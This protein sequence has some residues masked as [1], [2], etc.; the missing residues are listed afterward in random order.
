MAEYPNRNAIRADIARALAKLGTRHR[1]ELLELLG[2]PPDLGNVPQSFWDRVRKET[3]DELA[4]A[5][6]IAAIIAM[7]QHGMDEEAADLAGQILASERAVAAA[8]MITQ[9]SQRILRRQMTR[10]EHAASVARARAAG[11]AT[12]APAAV[13]IGA[14]V[15]EV[16]PLAAAHEAADLIFGP[17]RIVGIARN[18]S[19]IIMNEGGK[20]AIRHTGVVVTCWWR[21][22]QQA[23]PGHAGANI[24]PCEICTPWLDTEEAFWP[25]DLEPGYAHPQCDCFRSWEEIHTGRL[26]GE[27]G[28]DAGGA[29]AAA[30][31]KNSRSMIPILKGL[32]A[33][34]FKDG[35]GLS[36]SGGIVQ[37]IK[38][39]FAAC[40]TCGGKHGP[41]DPHAEPE[42]DSETKGL[43]DLAAIDDPRYGFETQ[44]LLRDRGLGDLVDRALLTTRLP[45]AYVDKDLRQAIATAAAATH[46]NPSPAQVE[47][48]N[49]P[50]GKFRVHRLE[51][52][53]E[54]PKG[55]TRSGTSAD[56][57]A[58]STVMQAHY[59]YIKRTESDAD[60][61]NIDVFI[62][63][64]PESELV[65]VVD[66]SDA[67]GRFDE[68][69]CMLG[70]HSLAEARQGYLDNYSRGWT[71]LTAITPMTLPEFH[72]WIT[73]YTG[74]P[75][76][77][78]WDESAH[79][80]VPSGSP[81]GGQFGSGAFADGQSSTAHNQHPSQH[82][83]IAEMG[84][85]SGT[86]EDP[87][88]CGKDL[89]LAVRALADGKAIQ[90]RQPRQVATLLHKMRDV[91]KECKLKGEE[92]PNF[93]LCLVSVPGTNLFC[94][95]SV[96]I[97]RAKMPQLGGKPMPNTPAMKLPINKKGEVDVSQLFIEHLQSIGIKVT[98]EMV[99]V[100]HLRASQSELVGAKVAAIMHQVE[101]GER[102]LNKGAIFATRDD[103]I[104]DGHHRWAGGIGVNLDQHGSSLEM[105][106][107][108]LDM[109]IG[110][111]IT[112]AN[113]WTRQIGIAPKE[114][115]S[116]GG[117]AMKLSDGFVR[118][119]LRKFNPD[120]A[121]DEHG[122][123]TE[124]G[125]HSALPHAD[126][127]KIAREILSQV[128]NNTFKIGPLPPT[129]RE[130]AALAFDRAKKLVK[131]AVFLPA[132]YLK[133]EQGRMAH[134]YHHL[135]EKYGKPMALA[136]IGTGLAATVGLSAM[137]VAEFVHH[138]HL[139][140]E[141]IAGGVATVLHLDE[142]VAA[143]PLVAAAEVYMRYRHG[144]DAAPHAAPPPAHKSFDDSF[145]QAEHAHIDYGH[146]QQLATEFWAHILRDA[147]D[148]AHAQPELLKSFRKFDESEARDDHGRWTSGG[149]TTTAPGD[150]KHELQVATVKPSST[151]V[152]G[153]HVNDVQVIELENGTKAIFKPESGM[154]MDVGRDGIDYGGPQREA[155]CS[156]VADVIGLSDLVPPTVVR[157]VDGEF[158]SVMKFVDDAD[159]AGDIKGP[160]KWDSDVDLQRAGAF[161][162]L[163][164]NTDRHFGNWMVTGGDKLQLIDNGLCLAPENRQ[165]LM[166]AQILM[167]LSNNDAPIPAEVQSWDWNKVEPAIRGQGFGDAE[168]RAAKERFDALRAADTFGELRQT[169]PAT[170]VLHFGDTEDYADL[171][172]WHN[173]QGETG[174]AHGTGHTH[175]TGVTHDPG[176]TRI[177]RVSGDSQE[178]RVQ[179]PPHPNRSQND[180]DN[181]T[182]PGPHFVPTVIGNA[183]ANDWNDHSPDTPLS[184]PGISNISRA[185]V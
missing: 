162:Y 51:I 142:I 17:E 42:P 4:A 100:S 178:M 49:Y 152:G 182:D 79:P 69:K 177:E 21:H 126:D 10:A 14:A 5:L 146:V 2:N 119:L 139:S 103:Y 82:V 19:N 180:Q 167:R 118:Q 91:V 20:V 74:A 40:G 28:D 109:D 12:G 150:A 144:H 157:E 84:G 27:P 124:G 145:D 34:M 168:V 112:L 175:G 184:R 174:S 138:G 98:E 136:I 37:G 64:D 114:A 156:D 93:N 143:A 77:K 26:I 108:R 104:L 94:H 76:A 134:E 107:H 60:G 115:K 81:G 97:P 45:K 80:R 158:G 120:E 1:R 106:V 7:T 68:H 102:D 73:G 11:V 169:G 38:P 117:W 149:T 25:P 147:I 15:A 110:A 130:M 36:T 90:L 129:L 75:V 160:R 50:K 154:D 13:P 16:S 153:R 105:N 170:W 56:G 141:I 183:T 179:R 65:F 131:T 61:D 123:W 83:T 9:T 92:A 173:N 39:E 31:S 85:H 59:G 18:E 24:A 63:P 55:S 137:H 135:K 185:T 58:W 125:A 30:A 181:G 33:Q 54:N 67:D 99:R 47:S 151:S 8:D 72:R 52:A 176:D 32:V 133:R 43:P 41:D 148:A 166:N 44:Q 22:T 96:G 71:G 46:R 171:D 48:G 86:R 140:P 62:G 165:Y 113:E 88:R 35:M 161:D 29:A 3:A 95:D 6:L 89:D 101:K 66:Q 87:I 70:Y 111:A 128:I 159:V 163:M 57:K 53:I 122:R 164:G 132:I 23:P 78:S 121:R 127:T 116:Y 155:V 172:A